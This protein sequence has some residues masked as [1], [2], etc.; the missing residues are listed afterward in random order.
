MACTHTRRKPPKCTNDTHEFAHMRTAPKPS[1]TGGPQVIEA[2][3]EA[4]FEYN[5]GLGTSML[6]AAL[7]KEFKKMA[8][9]R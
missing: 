6:K 9:A 5:G 4:F 3:R 8:E 2:L 7:T 1:G